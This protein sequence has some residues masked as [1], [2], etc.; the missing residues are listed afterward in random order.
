MKL[1]SFCC[2]LFVICFS[3]QVFAVDLPAEAQKM[4]DDLGTPEVQQRN[5]GKKMRCVYGGSKEITVSLLGGATIFSGDYNNCREAGSTR[6]GYYEVMVQ[7]GEIVGQSSKRSV[8]GELFD[9]AKADDITKAKSLIRKKADVNYTESIATTEGG[10]IHGWS[11]L[12]SAAMTGNSAMVKLLLKSGAWVNY[13][14]S[15]VVNALWLAA[16]NGN[17]DVVKMLV[18]NRAYINN[19]NVE[20]ITP[21]MNAAM[22]G[23]HNVVKY[24]IGSKADMNLV[25]K[26][27]DSALMFALAYGHSDAARVLV[28]AGANVNIQNKYGVTALIIAATEGNEDMVRLL[29][30]KKA[31]ITARIDAGKTA[32]DIASSKG[33]VKIIELLRNY[34]DK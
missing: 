11:P 20:D 18:E 16:G 6:D 25:H 17:L 13:L 10:Y 23:H 31:D 12:M 28:D 27:G 24:L 29:L 22:N 14:N 5:S 4:L 1:I 3:L 19:K 9:A 32:L 33:N 30:L 2:A 21:L 34:S 15:R 7:N 8:N 26:D